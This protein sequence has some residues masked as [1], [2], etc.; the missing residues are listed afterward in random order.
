MIV[1]FAVTNFEGKEAKVLGIPNHEQNRL[2]Y[3]D[4]LAPLTKDTV[5]QFR[6][7]VW[8]LIDSTN[9][10]SVR[11]TLILPDNSQKV[12]V[13]HNFSVDCI[14][15]FHDQKIARGE[16]QFLA[17]FCLIMEESGI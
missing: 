14:Q 2:S 3:G 11:F 1:S 16:E 10:G 4:S 7:D 12:G 9:I 6:A 15:K 8:P 13:L 5:I 17:E